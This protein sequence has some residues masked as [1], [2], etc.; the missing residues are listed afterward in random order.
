MAAQCRLKR[1]VEQ[2]DGQRQAHPLGTLPI[3]PLQDRAVGLPAGNPG[4]QRVLIDRGYVVAHRWF[5]FQ[6]PRPMGR[7]ASRGAVGD[8]RAHLAA[9]SS[10][11]RWSPAAGGR[12]T[13]APARPAGLE[14]RGPSVPRA[15]GIDHRAP[16]MARG[17]A[18]G[19]SRSLWS[20]I[21]TLPRS[22]ALLAALREK[23]PLQL[24]RHPEPNLGAERRNLRCKIADKALTARAKQDSQCA[25]HRQVNLFRRCPTCSLVK[26]HEPGMA[27]HRECDGLGL[28]PVEVA[29]EHG[30]KGGARYRPGFKPSGRQRRANC[31]RSGAVLTHVQLRQDRIRDEYHPALIM[32]EFKAANCGEAQKW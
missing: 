16:L 2:L 8:N 14:A 27:L 20:V 21:T 1:I 10:S 15:T 9:G 12:R 6:P 7:R 31:L 11:D 24:R 17:V 4:S 5:D 25:C 19:L 23:S 13:S 32:E 30:D 29:A 18:V 3:E 22:S 28:A 26:Q